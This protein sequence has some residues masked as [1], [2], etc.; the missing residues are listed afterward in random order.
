MGKW[1]LGHYESTIGAYDESQDANGNQSKWA[2]QIL[3]IETMTESDFWKWNWPGKVHIWIRQELKLGTLKVF[4]VEN[5]EVQSI[6]LDQSR[7]SSYD[8][9]NRAINRYANTDTSKKIEIPFGI[10]LENWSNGFVMS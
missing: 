3:Q 8:V 10:T 2:T 4:S 6:Q 9:P 5:G 1:K 7:I